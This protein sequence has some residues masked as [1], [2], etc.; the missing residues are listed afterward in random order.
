MIAHEVLQ[1]MIHGHLETINQHT[2]IHEE[3]LQRSNTSNN[4]SANDLSQYERCRRVLDECEK[5]IFG[6]RLETAIIAKAFLLDSTTS[7]MTNKEEGLSNNNE[8]K[9]HCSYCFRSCENG[10]SGGGKCKL[11]G[12]SWYCSTICSL[13][14]FEAH[15]PLCEMYR[16]ITM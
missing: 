8:D 10:D 9:N 7:T 13:S 1:S 3:I 6:A 4:P 5:G 15:R 11:C 14:H 16:K 12:Q 2:K